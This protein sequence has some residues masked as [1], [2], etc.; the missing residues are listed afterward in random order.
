MI[1]AA[2]VGVGHMGEYH[3]RVYSELPWVNLEGVVDIKKDRAEEIAKVYHTQPYTDYREIIGKVD[4]VSVAV[5]TSLHYQITRDFLLHGVNV[6][7]EKP[8]TE[9]LQQARELFEIARDCKVTLHVGHVE[10]FNGAIQEIIKIVKEPLFIEARRLGPFLLRD[11]NRETGVIM[12]LMI[13]DIDIILQLVK[14]P[15][16]E[17]SAFGQSVLSPYIDI[18]NVQLLFTSG[19]IASL[20]AS[21][22][23]ED[24]FRTLSITQKGVYIFLDYAT[25]DVH[26]S[27]QG[28]SRYFTT[29]EEVKYR[30][31]V[32][33]ER[34]FVHRGNPLRREIE[35]FLNTIGSSSPN[36]PHNSQ[37]FLHELSSLEIALEIKKRLQKRQ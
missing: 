9:N 15:L 1:K 27:R 2:V 29:T 28:N 8:I 19:C 17:I 10:R 32:V 37:S 20:T 6:L 13:H 4:A 5:P 22:I 36:N 18:A 14:S 7:V 25:Q 30:Q 24:K 21:R 26:I 34:V 11:G 35:H 3:T 23:T 16:Q 33:T 31:E 12:D